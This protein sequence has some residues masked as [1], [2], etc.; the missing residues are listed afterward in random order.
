MKALQPMQG[1]LTAPSHSLAYRRKELPAVSP[2]WLRHFQSPQ[3]KLTTNQPH[4]TDRIVFVK[5]IALLTCCVPLHREEAGQLAATAPP[6]GQLANVFP[7][8]HHS[9]S[10][11]F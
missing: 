6:V 11:W 5:A 3:A 2:H 10:A 8:A 7:A 9:V 4:P 1:V